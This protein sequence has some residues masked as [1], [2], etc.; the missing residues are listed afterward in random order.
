[1]SAQLASV[2]DD[3]NEQLAWIDGFPAAGHRYTLMSV[4]NQWT[5]KKLS[6]GQRVHGG[7]AG[8]VDGVHT[9]RLK[10]GV[11]VYVYD[12]RVDDADLEA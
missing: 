5:D 8:V 3:D 4:A 7:W 10:D 6:D 1:M 2:P 11:L 12:V 9:K